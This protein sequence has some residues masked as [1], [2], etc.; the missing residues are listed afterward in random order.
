MKKTLYFKFILAY[1][2]LAI[3]G[4]ILI[5]TVGSSIL[6]KQIKK[7]QGESMY[8]EAITI[9]SETA[10]LYGD[11]EKIEENHSVLSALSLYHENQIL[12]LN[13]S[14]ILLF[15]S[16]T[17]SKQSEKTALP[18]FDPTCMGNKQYFSGNFFEYFKEDMLNV[19]VPVTK[20]LSIRGY[21]S[22]HIPMEQIVEHREHLLIIVYLIF[23][24]LFGMS[25]GILLLFSLIVYRPLKKITQGAN[26]YAL[27]NLKHN[28][29]V[30]SDDE[31]GYLATTLN[32]MSN[33]LDKMGEYQKKFVANVSHDFRSPLT[34]I[35]GFIEAIMDGTI[36]YEMQDRYL[37]IVVDETERLDKLTRSLLTLDKLDSKGHPLHMVSFDI[38]NVIKNTAASFEA[39]CHNKR[40]TIEVHLQGEQLFVTA[41]MQQIQQVL[42]NLIDNAIKFSHNDSSI[43]VDTSEKYDTVF[44]SVKDTGIGIP[45]ESLG[46]IWDRFYKQDTSRGKDRKGTG[47]GLSIV[48]EII[49]A[50]EQNIDVISTE[51][52]GT[53]FIFTLSKTK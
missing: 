4:F 37:K 6:Q 27:G 14:G 39:V 8:K 35:K 23:L 15:D 29:P 16:K 9:A 47:L 13:P 2:F 1:I 41:D 36:P 22:M 24:L 11:F 52:A 18:N 7:M 50:H 30:N 19:L 42:Y 44:V 28:I 3:G 49:N 38:N 5:A 10:K 32:Y 26:E 17:D 51:G 21:I 48:K 25:L 46:K 43:K 34:S 20:D 45:K 40:I 33:E 31:M 12:I 53:E